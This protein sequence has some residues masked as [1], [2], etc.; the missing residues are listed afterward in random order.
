[1]GMPDRVEAGGGASGP[2]LLPMSRRYVNVRLRGTGRLLL[3]GARWCDSFFCRLRGLMFRRRLHPG[4]ALI[5]VEP[6]ESRA[7]T[8]IHMFFVPFP[9]A[10]IWINSAGKIV[11]KVKARP[12][13]PYYAPR[14][15]A[16][17]TLE[18]APEL[19]HDVSIGDDVDFETAAPA[20]GR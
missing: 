15:P 17:Y 19:L 6:G 18:A 7:A 9:I 13:R 10:A 14:A 12:W 2:L 16:R 1:M 8:S 20:A 4:E 11:D 5:L 3:S